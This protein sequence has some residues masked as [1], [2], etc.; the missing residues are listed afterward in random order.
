[1]TGDI[2]RDWK[3]VDWKAERFQRD[4]RIV[5]TASVNGHQVRSYEFSDG[6]PAEV[7]RLFDDMLAA[8]KQ[9]R[10]QP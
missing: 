5:V 4:E 7:A 3:N 9:H 10:G 6:Q 2:N 1:M 8:L